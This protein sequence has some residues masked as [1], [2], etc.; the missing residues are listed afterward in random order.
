[1]DFSFYTHI[2]KRM[3]RI[4]LLAKARM[5]LRELES[6][7]AR[8]SS[9]PNIEKKNKNNL[10]AFAS[11]K[12]AS[13]LNENTT[14]LSKTAGLGLPYFPGFKNR[15][16]PVLAVYWVV[17]AILSIVYSSGLPLVIAGWLSPT[18]IMLW[19]VA[20]RFGF[21][22]LEYRTPWFIAS[23]VSMAGVPLTVGWIISI[24]FTD[25]FT[26]YLALIILIVLVIAGFG[27]EA[28][29]KRAF[30]KP[31]KMFFRPD[32]ILGPNRILAGGLA[33][34]A[35]GMKFMFT[36]S[37]PGNV[38]IGNW[39]AFFMIIVL[40]LYQLIPLRGLTKMRTMVSRML[41]DT[42][43]GYGVTVL[44]ELYLVGA[45]T[46][47]LFAAHNFFAGVT[48]FSRNVLAGSTPGLIIMI[49][50]GTA[51]VLLRA[52]YKKKIGD[53]FFVETAAQSILKD[54]ILVV[55]MTIYFYGYVNVMVGGFPRTINSGQ[56]GY[57]TL[58]GAGLYAAGVILL[59]PIRAWARQNLKFGIMQQMMHV[60][61]PSLD[62]ES[63]KKVVKK[64]ILAISQMPEKMRLQ[65]V[66]FHIQNL[67]SMQEEDRNKIMMTQLEVLSELPPENRERMIRAMDKAMGMG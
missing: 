10:N 37:P 31:V 59:I 35:I 30:G 28:A 40:G 65:M 44:K 3:R 55:G 54:I 32:L 6:L 4:S 21:S 50:S 57:L 34:L 16:L 15:I 36:N 67:E 23:V 61:I 43:K 38:P 33:S 2:A 19:P 53:P 26:K 20:R 47:M 60:L 42:K 1:M 18:T 45:I 63:R 58:I 14:S 27:V 8:E 46:I 56:Y 52:W 48:P 12:K 7:S 64:V 11:S 29:H 5:S 66:K 39:Y 62:S 13:T 49:L 9:L 24:P 51:T 41:F 17:A 25:A 22:Y